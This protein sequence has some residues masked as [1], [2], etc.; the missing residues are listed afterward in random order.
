M[1]RR[2]D[3]RI[4]LAGAAGAIGR[5]LCPLLID[6]GWHVAGTTRSANRAAALRAIGVEPV[7]VDVFDADALRRAIAEAGATIVIHQLTDLSL[8]ADPARL[9]EARQRNTRLREIGTR[10]LIEASIASG[11]TRMIAQSIA[12]AY[13][14]GPV[15]YR[16]EAPLNL[17]APDDAGVTARGVASL[18]QQVMSAPFDAIIL[19]YGRFYGPGTLAAQPPKNGPVHIDAAAHAARLAVSRGA[20]GVYNV[21]E[22]DGTVDSCKALRELGWRADFRTT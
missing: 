16:E 15:P 5:R 14:P 2:A 10:N 6:D 8:I 4:F 13:A 21:A 17:G 1:T 12:F 7:L 19:R 9:A 3:K 22:D 11:V 20:A 18:E